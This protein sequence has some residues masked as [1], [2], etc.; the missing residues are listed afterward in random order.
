MRRKI[1]YAL[2]MLAVIGT[3]MWLTAPAT[4]VTDGPMRQFLEKAHFSEL[5]IRAALY[6]KTTKDVY[7]PEKRQFTHG[8]PRTNLP[9]IYEPDVLTWELAMAHH[10]KTVF[11]VPPTM[12]PPLP[13]LVAPMPMSPGQ[14]LPEAPGQVMLTPLGDQS[15]AARP[16]PPNAEETMNRML[17]R[18]R[19]QGMTVQTPLQG[20]GLRQRLT[21]H[22][23]SLNTLPAE[24]P[25]TPAAPAVGLPPMAPTR[26]AK[27]PRGKAGDSFDRN[28]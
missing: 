2:A 22:M 24:A 26:P 21:D 15:Y 1:H 13:E 25:P 18:A 4:A 28:Y 5:L 16:L 27:M 8:L 10:R 17:E 23:N 3:G 7:V 12:D 20:Q 9:F 19:L 11:D 14:I 6:P